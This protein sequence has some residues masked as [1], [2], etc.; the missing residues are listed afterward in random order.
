MVHP[1]TGIPDIP[2]HSQK[3]AVTISGSFSER[4]REI[5]IDIDPMIFIE[6]AA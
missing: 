2:P 3:N 1:P 4:H 6:N 5:P